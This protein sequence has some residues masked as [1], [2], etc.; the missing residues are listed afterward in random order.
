VPLEIKAGRT[1]NDDFF[2]NISYWN[3]LSGNPP[4]RSFVVCGGDTSQNRK[5]GRVVSFDHPDPVMEFL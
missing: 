1:V 2:K 3:H 5:K 4:E